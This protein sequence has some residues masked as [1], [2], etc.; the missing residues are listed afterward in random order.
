MNVSISF[1]STCPTCGGA[2]IQNTYTRGTLMRLLELHLPLA[3]SCL[4]C[5]TIWIIRAQER[6]RAAEAVAASFHAMPPAANL[7]VESRRP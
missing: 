1:A 4:T 5:D 6:D 2:R 3:G 7:R